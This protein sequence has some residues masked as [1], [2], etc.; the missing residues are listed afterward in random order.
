MN[1]PKAAPDLRGEENQVPELLYR[2]P[3]SPQGRFLSEAQAVRPQL[4][5]YCSRMLGSVL[6]G[7]DVVQDT[8]ATT[9]FRLDTVDSSRP[10]APLL[11]RIAHNRC[12]DILRRRRFESGEE[13]PRERSPSESERE[14]DAE[15]S[16]ILDQQAGRALEV[17]VLELPARQRAVF[18]LK[19]VLD[20]TLA[21]SAEILGCSV[22]A[23]KSALHRARAR[24][25]RISSA[26][27]SPRESRELTAAD[28]ELLGRYAEC[29]NARNW[30]ELAEL[31]AEDVRLDVVGVLEEGT[32]ELIFERYTVNYTE[33]EGS[34]RLHVAQVD[35]ELALVCLRQRDGEPEET[36]AWAIRVEIVDGKVT[37][38]R[39]YVIQHGLLELAEI[40][41]DP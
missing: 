22:G 34:W 3:E 17:L 30:T 29:F 14:A 25:R 39:D 2:D 20:H 16:V 4:H 32:S 28:V 37:G 27:E 41:L 6:D 31:L 40:T 33:L 21:E 19:D 24:L 5:R 7:E 23:V 15:E 10:L 38:L 8:L 12:I 35:G 36:I 11:F 13:V 9:F 1:Q 18:L 26:S